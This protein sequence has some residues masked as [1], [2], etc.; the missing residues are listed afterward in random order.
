VTATDIN[1]ELLAL[2]RA[3]AGGRVRFVVGD[4]RDLDIDSD[5]FD[6]VTC[7]FDSIGYAQNNE[8]VIAA[9]RSLGRYAAP[10]G[11]VVCEF[12]HAPALLSGASPVRV[13]RRRMRDGRTLL[14]VSE[15]TLDVERMLMR[16][17]YELL[18][19]ADDG[20]VEG[21]R[22]VQ[23]NRFF[24]VPEIRLLA[25]TAGLET[26]AVVP[27]YREDAIDADTFHV[28]LVATPLV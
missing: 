11:N 21:A 27:A 14:R 18:V 7:L 16:V 2:A 12:L 4:M 20:R 6:V 8:G 13:L 15:T 26:R 23:V 25:A 1:D 9:L 5:F 10:G 28:M 3:A 24:S 22:E 17:E 19:L